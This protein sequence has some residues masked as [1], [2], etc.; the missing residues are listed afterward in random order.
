MKILL[1]CFVAAVCSAHAADTL[2]V[3]A[4]AE[5]GGDG[6]SWNAPYRY[7]DDAIQHAVAGDEVW[8]A[9]GTY[10][11]PA[12]GWSIPNGVRFYGG[13]AGN[14]LVREARDWFRRPVIIVAKDRE[15]AFVMNNCDS[16]TRLDGV[17]IRESSGSAV[18]V[19]GGTPRIVNCTMQS[20]TAPAGA[21]ILADGVT[22]IRIEYCVFDRNTAQV[23][24]GAVCIRNV[25]PDAYGFGPFIAQCQFSNNTVDN[26]EGGALSIT[27]CPTTPQITSCVFNGNSARDGGA[28][29]TLN[30][31]VYIVN[32]TFFR[33]TATGSGP[34]SAYTLALHGGV[35]MNSIVWNGDLP[36]GAK[37]VVDIPT[38]IPED[39][40]RI[41]AVANNIEKDF[42]Y[43][44]WQM[45]PLFEDE[46][47][48]TG[49]DGFFGTDDDGL[50]LSRNSISRD[51]GVIDRFVNHRQTDA[52]GN[53]RLVGR[54]IDL[55]AYESQRS[56]RLTPPQVLEEIR[57]GT[58]T[59]YFRHAK[60]DWGEKD[61]GPSPECF[62]GRNLIYE[63]REQSREIG[64]AQLYL[65]V[66]IGDVQS[67]TACRCWETVDLMCG[68]YTKMSVWAGGGTP[69][70]QKVR[71]SILKTTP[72][73]GNRV[74]SSHDAVAVA[75]YNREGTGEVLTTA[76]LMEGDVL[77]TKPL[78]DTFEVVAHWCSDTWERYHVRFPDEP[79]SV[80]ADE[81]KGALACFPNP[82][83]NHVTIQAPGKAEVQIV[84]L[85]GSLVWAGQVNGSA[86]VNIS[87]WTAGVYTVRSTL[88]TVRIVVHR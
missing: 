76:E 61:P 62:P 52:I 48:P 38:A 71:D 37:H 33:N 19:T 4:I 30:T 81:M 50:R 69:N 17:V 15:H 56:G 45:D 14:E 80:M 36:D 86:L 85:L 24:G 87:T 60:T 72:V 57:N 23:E 32:S 84:D 1:F 35:L 74:I 11:P 47:S 65:G 43:G 34:A 83:A 70:S 40:N 88:G 64:K 67:S 68:K 22:R 79:T 73:G 31:F 9:R 42:D 16:T 59:F 55:G 46:S 75:T 21:A 5:P 12:S 3:A 18:M 54:R 49:A 20:N 6:Q 63:G 2:F 25:Q 8:I 66:P 29:Y 7:L 10:T 77:F 44:F 28:V 13:F 26:G 78:G 58:Y 39:T 53:P 51:N 27:S 41:S 82:T